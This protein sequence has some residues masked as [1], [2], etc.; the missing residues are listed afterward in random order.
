MY[1]KEQKEKDL[2][3][4]S[5]NAIQNAGKIKTLQR[6]KTEDICCPKD[7][8]V[9]QINRIYSQLEMQRQKRKC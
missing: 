9:V 5:E 7:W 8:K 1:F 3:I 2:S 4:L 6:N